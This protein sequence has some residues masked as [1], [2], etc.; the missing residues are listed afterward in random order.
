ML[1]WLGLVIF[2]LWVTR[3]WFRQVLGRLQKSLVLASLLPLVVSV[4]LYTSIPVGTKFLGF[5]CLVLSGKIMDTLAGFSWC[6]PGVGSNWWSTVHQHCAFCQPLPFFARYPSVAF[7]IVGCNFSHVWV[8]VFVD[9][10]SI[11]S[12][13]DC[14][15]SSKC[16]LCKQCPGC[17]FLSSVK[18]GPQLMCWCLHSCL[19]SFCSKKRPSSR[20]SS[21]FVRHI[22]FL[23]RFLFRI[24]QC[25]TQTCE[26]HC[27]LWVLW[28]SLYVNCA[29][30]TGK[31]FKR[32]Q[33]PELAP[34]V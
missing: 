23:F 7:T 29:L 24:A 32:Q 34:G 15:C 2:L 6:F 8:L 10:Q 14:S 22:L 17:L 12:T 21:V 16:W 26:D 11:Y 33:T 25:M 5:A 28:S 9:L 20:V 3:G 4:T 19:P 1:I 27:D 13:V 31:V 30:V 18:S